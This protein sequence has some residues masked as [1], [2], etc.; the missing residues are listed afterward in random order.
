MGKTHRNQKSDYPK[1][2]GKGNQKQKS[3][4]KNNNKGNKFDDLED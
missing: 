4:K 2:K 1:P 3:Q